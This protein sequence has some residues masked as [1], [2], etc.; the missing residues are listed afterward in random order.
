MFCIAI[1]VLEIKSLNIIALREFLNMIYSF[2][3][4]KFAM[5]A[6]LCTA[7]CFYVVESDL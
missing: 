6:I 3:R 7:E 5:K 4:Y 1:V 2:R